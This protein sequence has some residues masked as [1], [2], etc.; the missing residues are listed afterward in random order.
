MPRGG[1][2]GIRPSDGWP[3]SAM[4]PSGTAGKNGVVGALG[5]IFLGVCIDGLRLTS[6][7]VRPRALNPSARLCRRAAEAELVVGT[8][9]RAF[10]RAATAPARACRLDGVAACFC[11]REAETED[12]CLPGVRTPLASDGRDAA[13]ARWDDNL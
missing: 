2:V 9:S 10:L 11:T 5:M 1:K 13:V 6:S 4:P 12:R 8:L 3:H 7:L